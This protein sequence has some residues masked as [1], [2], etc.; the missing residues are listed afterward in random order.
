MPKGTTLAKRVVATLLLGGAMALAGC[1]S[2]GSLSK[3]MAAMQGGP[4]GYA[5]A[6]W[7]EPHATETLGDGTLMVWRDYA[8]AYTET[9]LPVVICERQLAVDAAGSISGWRWRGDACE[10]LYRDRAAIHPLQARQR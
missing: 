9:V 6:I 10:S 2:A 4:A 5:T 3:D 7:G 8:G 1:S